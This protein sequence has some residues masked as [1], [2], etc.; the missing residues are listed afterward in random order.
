MAAL[1]ASFLVVALAEMGDKTQLIALTLG[2]RY[3]RPWTVMLGILMA[4]LLNH[5]LAAALGAW[6]AAQ[7]SPRALGW[8]LGL[9][10]I[11]FGIW[12]LVPDRAQAPAERRGWGPLLT[13][14]VVFFL[15]EMGDKTQL[16]TAALGARYASTLAVTLGTTAGMLAA[17][18]LAVFAGHRFAA[19]VPLVLLRR[20]AAAL[21]FL[22]G[23]ASIVAAEWRSG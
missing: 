22:F 11:G 5:S 21:F 13:T 20:L 19:I 16:A 8:I 7:V 4:T 2:M 23:I 12:T 9:G 17:D 3:R 14:T 18:A 15:A 1:V 6:G 10:F